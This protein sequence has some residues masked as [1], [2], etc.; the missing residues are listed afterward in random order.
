VIEKL[1]RQLVQR[2]RSAALQCELDLADR[3]PVITSLNDS[4]V[5]RDLDRCAGNIEYAPASSKGGVKTGRRPLVP[6]AER[7]ALG[8]LS[9]SADGT[10]A[11]VGNG[12]C[13]SL[14]CIGPPSSESVF[15]VCTNVWPSQRTRSVMPA[16][17]R[18]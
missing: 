16:R 18:P 4:L 12:A 10:R 8:S 3:N 17:W 5:E 14:R 1:Q 6:R 15:S 13:H 11:M 9:A 2:G 7:S